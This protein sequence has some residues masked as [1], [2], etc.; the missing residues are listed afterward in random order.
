MSND[1]TLLILKRFCNWPI[2]PQVKSSRNEKRV[3][4]YDE[5]RNAHTKNCTECYPN[6]SLEV[7]SQLNNVL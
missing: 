1:R 6:T 3:Q 7:V 2:G 5:D 4:S